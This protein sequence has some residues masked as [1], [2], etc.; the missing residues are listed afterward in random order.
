[1][2]PGVSETNNN[3]FIKLLV[4]NLPNQIQVLNFTYRYAIFGRYD[5][6]HLHWLDRFYRASSWFKSAVKRALLVILIIR[7]MLFKTPVVWTVH[8]KQPHE[9]ITKIEEKF[10]LMMM[11]IIKSRVFLVSDPDFN[12]KL[13]FVI[14]HGNYDCEVLSI[15]NYLAYDQYSVICIGFLRPSKNIVNLIQNFP[16]QSS[17]KL[18]VAGEAISQEYL[19]NIRDACTN[20]LDVILHDKRLSNEELLLSYKK[21]FCSI[22][23]YVNV[24]NSG[25]A[26]FALSVPRPVIATDSQSMR[27]LQTEVG[28]LWLQ[29]I[30]QDFN[31]QDIQQALQ[32]LRNSGMLR[33]LKSPLSEKRQWKRIGEA[34]FDAY[35]SILKM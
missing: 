7:I 32:K 27:E 33:Q 34:Y 23:P 30:P 9:I 4:N 14:P 31:S 20:K 15:K 22:I 5:I 25:A 6:L 10:N 11:K 29:L 3:Q 8:N 24:Y 2:S 17:F 28:S 35:Q 21:S 1:M 19:E 16:S 18:T 26:L 13:D 12:L